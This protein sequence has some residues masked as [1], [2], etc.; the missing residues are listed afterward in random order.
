[1]L[2]LCE[3]APDGRWLLYRHHLE[4]SPEGCRTSIVG[5]VP[6]PK[7]VA[8]VE[9]ALKSAD[10]GV[11]LVRHPG[12]K[13]PTPGWNGKPPVARASSAA[14][15]L[16]EQ[17]DGRVMLYLRT[18]SGTHAMGWVH[19]RDITGNREDGAALTRA[20]QGAI[21]ATGAAAELQQA[22]VVGL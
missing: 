22:V 10:V 8:V 3:Q 14:F 12:S 21:T 4:D 17:A 9:H 18:A 13:T 6:N 11:R 1:M 19:P 16:V 15:E 20:L 7:M 2:D 5:L